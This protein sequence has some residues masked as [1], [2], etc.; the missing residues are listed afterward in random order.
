MKTTDPRRGGILSG[1]L[2]IGAGLT[3]LVVVSA[4][5]LAHNIRVDARSG[6]G[7]ENVSMD[8][9]GG[10]LSVRAHD[11]LDPEALGVPVYPGAKRSRDHSGGAVFEWN[12]ADGG[13][14]KGLSVAGGETVTSDSASK[15]LDYYRRE[16][17]AWKIVEERD[18]G[19]RLELDKGGYKRFIAI[20][21]KS[22]GTHI[23]IASV[24]EATAN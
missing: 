20:E 10:H 11:G 9:P 4:I 8:I 17:P 15:V 2:L 22:D 18:G 12:P 1:L 21:E 14:N 23:G 16:L 24:G 5:Y 3:C 6:A 13:E 19:T 7:G